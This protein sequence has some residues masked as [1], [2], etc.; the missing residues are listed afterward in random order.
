MYYVKA[1]GN[2]KKTGKWLKIINV[3]KDKIEDDYILEVKFN[4]KTHYAK[5]TTRDPSVNNMLFAKGWPD[6]KAVDII[7]VIK[8][9]TNKN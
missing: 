4:G 8:D 9:L 6:L 1:I 2:N 3:T 7:E 5:V